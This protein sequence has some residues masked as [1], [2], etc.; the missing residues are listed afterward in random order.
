MKKPLKDFEVV[1]IFVFLFLIILSIISVVIIWTRD[2]SKISLYSKIL[3]TLLFGVISIF[4]SGA[5]F[6]IITHGID[7]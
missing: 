1:A 6:H 7:N 5:M 4:F 2:I 3:I